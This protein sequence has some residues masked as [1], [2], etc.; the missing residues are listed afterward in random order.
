MAETK[1]F[2]DILKYCYS[3]GVNNNRTWFHD[4]HDEYEKAKKDFQGFL[5]ML[6]FAI[7]KAAPQAGKP[8]MYMEPREWMY[9]IARDMRFHKNGAP[10]N[11]AFR[12]YLAPDKKSW[13]PEGYYIRIFPGSSC[14][15]TGLWCETTSQMNNIR[16]YISLH[17]DEFS[18]ILKKSRIPVEG[19]SLK[20]MPRGFSADDPAAKYIK[21]KNWTMIIEIPDSD[22]GTFEDFTAYLIKY[23]KRMEPM[24]QFL[25]KASQYVDS[26]RPE[27]EW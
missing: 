12:A 10:Y 15:G 26:G 3:L 23:V 19:S 2:K 8:I 16:K 25:M 20:S 24:R 17:Y 5:D 27:F 13:K 18:A 1:D 7:N 11:P 14:F 4:H 21:M 9:R 6:R 22:I